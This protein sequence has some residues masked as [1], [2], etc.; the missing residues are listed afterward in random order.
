MTAEIE[1]EEL[2]AEAPKPALRRGRRGNGAAAAAGGAGGARSTKVRRQN[3]SPAAPAAM[4]L[5]DGRSFPAPTPWSE[6]L[7][8]DNQ[9]LARNRARR[10]AMKTRFPVDELLPA[11]WVGLLKAC[12]YYDPERINP[13]SGRPYRLSSCAVPFIDGAIK[14][15]LR[16]CGYA[17]KLP[18]AW[19]EQAPQIRRLAN[20]G[21]T[22]EQIEAQ[23]GMPAD[24]VR[25]LLLVTGQ[26]K[27][28]QELRVE[29]E[30]P[31]RRGD[32]IEHEE[33]E[34]DE[35]AELYDLAARA[36]ARMSAGDQRLIINGW[37]AR[38]RFVP[39]LPLGQF[40]VGVRKLTGP[41]AVAAA[42]VETAPIGFEVPR[43][44]ADQPTR[45]GR[46]EQTPA[47][48]AARLT[49]TAEQ[50]GLFASLA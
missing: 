45:A 32:P 24:E 39:S 42:D 6:Q 28:L 40:R 44:L 10:M 17:L 50:L 8:V 15:Y 35:L 4:A 48:A 49:E 14:Q 20:E 47:G 13:A 21:K 3:P 31:G 29:L 2:M 38:R 34:C 25:Q 41:L 23:V 30:A 5:A 37:A 26:Q 33:E 11:A 19:R 22:P 43:G 7:A 16:D 27:P 1:A 18:H 9:R 12:R 36:W 46:V